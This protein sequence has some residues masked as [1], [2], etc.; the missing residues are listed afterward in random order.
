MTNLNALAN[1]LAGA[2]DYLASGVAPNSRAAQ[3][4]AQGSKQYPV[5]KIL[6]NSTLALLNTCPRKFSLDVER[7]Q[8]RKVELA[9]RQHQQVVDQTATVVSTDTVDTAFGTAFGAGAQALWLTNSLDRAI[10]ALVSAWTLPLDDEKVKTRKSFYYCIRALQ[11]YHAQVYT[12]QLAEGWQIATLTCDDGRTISGIEPAC[13][14]PLANDYRYDLHIDLILYHPQRNVYK[15][16]EMKTSGNTYFHEAMFANSRQALGYAAVIATKAKTKP[17]E[18]ECEYLVYMTIQRTF[19]VIE[20]T[21]TGHAVV[22]FFNDIIC[23]ANQVETYVQMDYFPKR[24]TSCMDYG[25][26]CYH[27][28]TC[29]YATKANLKDKLFYAEPID[30]TVTM[31]AILAHYK[32]IEHDQ[33]QQGTKKD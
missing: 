31:E 33:A 15:I 3:L 30:V 22:Q 10:L 5:Y 17:N 11:A 14:I 28:G 32:I 2:E 21:I 23:E 13:S 8:Q 18:I 19:N 29:D 16:V 25:N 24:G 20:Q 1:A 12:E 9:A 26:P 6:S 27:Y 4:R 7:A